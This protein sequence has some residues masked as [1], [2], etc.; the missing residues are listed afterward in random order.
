MAFMTVLGGREGGKP[1]KASV[2][3]RAAKDLESGGRATVQRSWSWGSLRG[4]REEQDLGQDSE[5]EQED[6]WASLT[7]G[8]LFLPGPQFPCL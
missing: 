5:G 3:G 1:R 4:M 6:P 2:R 8:G 7:P